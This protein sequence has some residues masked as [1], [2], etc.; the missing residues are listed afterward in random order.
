MFCVHLPGMLIFNGHKNI[1]IL[2]V[3]NF[4]YIYFSQLKLFIKIDRNDTEADEVYKDN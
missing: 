2:F 1:F 4:Y 3:I